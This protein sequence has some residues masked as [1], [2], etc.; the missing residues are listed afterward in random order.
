MT[1]KR[2]SAEIQSDFV[3]RPLLR[4]EPLFARRPNLKSE[5][6]AKFLLET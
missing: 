5:F 4:D 1:P 6:T 3:E 2:P